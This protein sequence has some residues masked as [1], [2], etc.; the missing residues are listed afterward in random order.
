MIALEASW[1]SHLES[2]FKKDYMKELKSF[3]KSELD[4]GKTIYPH[5]NEI[6]SA[7]HATPF[8][9]VKVVIIGQDPYHGPGQA[10]GMCFSVKKGVRPPPSLKNIYKELE[11]DLGITTPDHGFLMDWAQQGVLLINSVLTVEA[12]SAGSHQKKG[13]EQFT[14]A[15]I[16]I[17]NKE[18][19]GLVFILWGSPAQKKAARVDRHRHHIIKSVHPSPLA[20]HRGFFGTRPFSRTNNYLTA[21]GRAPIDWSLS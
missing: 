6:F 13:W 19:E 1:L 9:Q 4:A 15:V 18:K 7:F 2:E 14:D 20:A 3:L 17:L 10:H 21:Q 16:D 5:G 12:A 8:D 11:S